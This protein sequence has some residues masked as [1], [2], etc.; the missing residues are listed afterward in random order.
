MPP[1][2]AVVVARM[3][4]VRLKANALK[5]YQTPLAPVYVIVGTRSR[6]RGGLSAPV[7][8]PLAG[9]AAIAG[10]TAYTRTLLRTV[11]RARPT[12]RVDDT[13]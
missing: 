12:A 3:P 8:R 13:L 2:D 1:C 10:A 6:M 5:I 4:R 11:L 9:R 7:F